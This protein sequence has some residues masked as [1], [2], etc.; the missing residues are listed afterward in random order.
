MKLYSNQKENNKKGKNYNMKTFKKL[1]ALLIAVVMTLGVGTKGVFAK[2]DTITITGAKT[3]ETYKAYK[4]FDLKVNDENNPTAYTYT[5]NSAWADFFKAAE[6]SNP[7]GAGAQYVTINASGAVTAISD[8][9]A[10]AKAAAEWSGKPAATQTKI[11]TGE[12]VEFTGLDDGYWLIT[13]TLGTIAMAET[14]PDK[15][16]VTIQEKNPED[17]IEKTVKED[18]TGQYGETNDAQ[19][20]DLVEFKSVAHLVKGTRNV[21]VYD[22]MT[23]GLTYTAGSVAIEGLTEGTQYTVEENKSITTGEGAD[24]VTTKYA[25]VITFNDAYVAGLTEPTTDLTI[26][27][28]ARINEGAV[29][30]DENGVAIVDQNNKTRVTYGDGTTSTEDTTTTKTHKF[31]VFKHAKDSTDNLAGAVFQL[32]KGTTVIKLIKLDDNNYRVAA[33]QT[34]TAG[35]HVAAD[36]KALATTAPAANSTVNDFVTVAAGD[37]VIWGVDS[38]DDYKLAEI[39][40]PEGYNALTAEQP[41]TFEADIATR[42]DVENNAGTEL[43]GTGGIGTTMFYV[44][45]GALILGAG[46]VLTARKKAQN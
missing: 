35:S 42:V 2:N 9:A 37:I 14:T 8:R 16:A 39:L 38:D 23:D 3:G 40:P 34:A 30:K 45:G 24:A 29:V 44:V 7:A 4:M 31:N 32:K 19:V 26:T 25:F 28:T 15:A 6:G 33:D 43:P 20:G 36:G 41:V 10:L 46:I 13:S 27:Y 17:T 5:V 12:T 18:S 1:A 11:A 22:R 21:K